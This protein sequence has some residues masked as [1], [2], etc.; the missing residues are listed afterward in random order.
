MQH[1]TWGFMHYLH[2]K[3]FCS[4]LMNEAQGLYNNNVINVSNTSSPNFC[5]RHC[6]K[7][8]YRPFDPFRSIC[9]FIHS[10]VYIFFLKL[11]LN[12]S[13]ILIYNILVFSIL[14]HLFSILSNR[15]FAVGCLM[16]CVNALLKF[17]PPPLDG[18]TE[19]PCS[20][21]NILTL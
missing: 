21:A 1:V 20:E 13:Y 6:N 7:T 19:P 10:T 18:A 9:V 3:S 14:L 17:G 2:Q 8:P 5:T 15:Y 12:I 11:L 4:C 16:D